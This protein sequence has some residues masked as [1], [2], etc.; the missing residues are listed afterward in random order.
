MELDELCVKFSIFSNSL[1]IHD[2][3]PNT[4]TVFTQINMYKILNSPFNI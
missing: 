3:V 1:K 2:S 4:V